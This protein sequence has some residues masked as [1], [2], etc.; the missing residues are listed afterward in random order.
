MHSPIETAFRRLC[1]G[2]LP[3]CCVTLPRAVVSFS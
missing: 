1:S 3:A 2:P